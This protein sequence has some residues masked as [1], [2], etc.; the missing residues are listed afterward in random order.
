MSCVYEFQLILFPGAHCP[1]LCVQNSLCLNECK[2]ISHHQTC[3]LLT[4]HGVLY[5]NPGPLPPCQKY[6][7]LAWSHLWL[8]RR[9]FDHLEKR[10]VHQ[11]FKRLVIFKL[12]ILNQLHY[13][14]LPSVIIN[15]GYLYEKRSNSSNFVR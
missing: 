2:S 11:C 7:H 3:H 1:N 14:E 5:H 10:E 12:A 6:F 8:E 15:Y 9:C 13:L 4:C